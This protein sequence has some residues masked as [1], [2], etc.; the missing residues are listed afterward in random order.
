V[1][2]IESPTLSR[3]DREVLTLLTWGHTNQQVAD[4]LE[5]SVTTAKTYI[6]F[7]YFEIGVTCRTQAVVWGVRNGLMGAEIAASTLGLVG[8]S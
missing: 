4:E 1:S 8:K 7:A 6:R 2:E 5:V 3:R